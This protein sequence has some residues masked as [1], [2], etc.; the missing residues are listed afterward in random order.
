MNNT[1]QK[2]YSPWPNSP[3][4]TGEPRGT[5]GSFL[6]NRKPM[7][8]QEHK[9]PTNIP[10]GES[11]WINGAETFSRQEVFKLLFTQRAMI[12]NDIKTVLGNNIPKELYEILEH[13]R[14]PKF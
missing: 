9:L 14:M 12:S 1:T 2:F 8:P 3:S 6:D 7:K 10:D 11:D 4:S 13:P 5:G